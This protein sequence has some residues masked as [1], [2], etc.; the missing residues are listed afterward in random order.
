MKEKIELYLEQD[1]IHKIIKKH[2]KIDDDIKME[3]NTNAGR[4]TFEYETKEEDAF[5]EVSDE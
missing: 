1:E 4:T 3:S 2:F 5:C